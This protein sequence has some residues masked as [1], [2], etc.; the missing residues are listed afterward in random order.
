MSS[1]S[2]DAETSIKNKMSIPSVFK[3][4]GGPGLCG[5]ANAMIQHIIPNHWKN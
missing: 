3:G 4:R 2:I 5:L 1:V